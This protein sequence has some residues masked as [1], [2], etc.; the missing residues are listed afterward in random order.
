MFALDTNTV[1]YFFR[2]VPS[3]V[4]AFEALAPRDIGVPDIVRYE[5]RRGLLSLPASRAR[6]D[7]MKALETL[8]AAVASLPFNAAAA[9][10]A[11]S[12]HASLARTGQTIGPLDTLIAAT[13]LAFD[14]TLVTNNQREFKRVRKLPLANWVQ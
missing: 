7:R 5:L 11:A 6:S 9:D 10:A 8:L 3:V 1:S 12:I 4:A 14:A 2:G 13:A